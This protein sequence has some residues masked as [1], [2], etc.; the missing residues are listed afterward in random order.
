MV[1]EMS[2][3]RQAIKYIKIRRGGGHEGERK[4]SKRD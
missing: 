3:K 1:R 2:Y 4:T